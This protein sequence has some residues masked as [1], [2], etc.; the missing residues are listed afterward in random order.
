MG[1]TQSEDTQVSFKAGVNRMTSPR[2]D[3][4]HMMSSTVSI[5]IFTHS[6]WSKCHLNVFRDQVVLYNDFMRKC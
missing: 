4:Y 2:D 3:V 5:F 6:C 1:L